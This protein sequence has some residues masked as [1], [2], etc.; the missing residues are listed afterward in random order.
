[1]TGPIICGVD[2]SRSGRRAARAARRLSAELGAG[3]VFVRVLDPSAGPDEICTVAKRLERLSSQAGAHRGA[4]WLVE[5]GAPAERL[6]TAAAERGG[7]MIVVG[8][9]DSPG[10]PGVA[11]DVARL[12]PCPVL[13]VPRGAENRLGLSFDRR[14]SVAGGIARLGLGGLTAG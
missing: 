8:A 1:L 13:V 5:T 2:D 6:A 14:G 11:T 9:S 7:S 12:A 4:T 10:V 3:L